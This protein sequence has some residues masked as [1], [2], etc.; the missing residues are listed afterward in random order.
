LYY[1]LFKKENSKAMPP[2][3]I[4]L[5]EVDKVF[6]RLSKRPIAVRLNFPA[7]EIVCDGELSG[8]GGKN[9]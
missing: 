3:G 4:A 7:I 9:C 8:L 1:E 5:Q 2:C 6:R